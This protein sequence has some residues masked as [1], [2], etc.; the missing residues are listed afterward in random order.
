[1][2]NRRK[3]TITSLDQVMPE[4]DRLL[5]GY[6]KDGNW[7]LGQVCNHLSAMV[8]CS[9]DGFPEQLPWL[10]RVTIGALKK[11]RVLATGMMPQGINLPDRHAPKPNLDDR[12]EAEA[13]R[14][15]LR[16]YATYAGAMAVHPAFG[17]STNAEWT[18]IHCIHIGHHLSFLRP[19]AEPA[20]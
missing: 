19:T 6:T 11:R 14:T 13:L 10:F 18:Q 8:V 1:M 7:S 15:A 5:E 17:P 20:A 9:M 12:I 4:V 16:R 2:S 3:L